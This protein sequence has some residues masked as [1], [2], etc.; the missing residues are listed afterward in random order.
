MQ[1]APHI[2]KF[3]NQ[4]TS[5]YLSATI[6]YAIKLYYPYTGGVARILVRGRS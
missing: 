5:P 1:F 6:E 3:A 4:K 2:A